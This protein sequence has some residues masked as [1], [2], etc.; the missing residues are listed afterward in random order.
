MQDLLGMRLED[1]AEMMRRRGLEP[2]IV[3]TC[4]PRGQREE[5][6]MRV[7]RVRGSELTVSRFQV[8]LPIE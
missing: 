3:F 6:E 7:I 2:E 5:G 1:A 4:A 8:D